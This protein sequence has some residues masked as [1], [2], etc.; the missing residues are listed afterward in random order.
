MMGSFPFFNQFMD[1]KSLH[2][3]FHCPIRKSGA[4]LTGIILLKMFRIIIWVMGNFPL[5]YGLQNNF[6]MTTK[7][8]IF[9]GKNILAA[10]DCKA[11]ESNRQC[12]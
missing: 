3:H 10:S 6:L 7:T 12:N 8:N 1:W 9:L 5:M 11:G 2:I 4:I